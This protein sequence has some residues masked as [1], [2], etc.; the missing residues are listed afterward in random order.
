MVLGILVYT[1]FS[2]VVDNLK[3]SQETFYNRENFADGFIKVRALPYD[4]IKNLESI[5]GIAQI[6]GR[7]VQDVQVYAPEKEQNIYLRSVSWIPPPLIPSMESVLLK[8]SL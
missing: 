8:V 1:S 6:E 3:L 7:I 4:K 2:I 5:Q